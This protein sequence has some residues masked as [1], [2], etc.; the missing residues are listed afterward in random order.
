MPDFYGATHGARA[1]RGAGARREARGWGGG[2]RI[3]RDDGHGGDAGGGAGGSG[4]GRSA[5]GRAWGNHVPEVAE[6]GRWGTGALEELVLEARDGGERDGRKCRVVLREWAQ[7]RGQLLDP[8]EGRGE[9][10]LQRIE[11]ASMLLVQQR[12]H[13]RV[14]RL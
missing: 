10:L 3:V 6:C 11:R 13:H 1:G 4:C 14:R 8:G 5:G 9:G 7:H 2:V 12:L